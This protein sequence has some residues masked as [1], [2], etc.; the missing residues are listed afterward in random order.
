MQIAAPLH[1]AHPL[2]QLAGQFEH[3][4]QTRSH[5]HERLPEPLWAQAVALTS[6][7]APSRVAKQVRLRGNDLKTQLRKRQGTPDVG[8]APRGCVE[9]PPA[10]PVPQECG[11]LESEW[12]RTD[13]T[14]MRMHAPD[15]SLPLAAIV[16]SFV[17]AR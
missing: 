7:L 8:P 5:P 13:G 4:R 2:D 15:A 6:A 9:V 10:P 14:R 11:G 16:Q 17:E 3:W 1:A 12:H